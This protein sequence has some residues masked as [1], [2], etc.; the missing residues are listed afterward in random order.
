MVSPYDGPR[1]ACAA[2]GVLRGRPVKRMWPDALLHYAG[3]DVHGRRLVVQS[4]EPR[5][6]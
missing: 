5:N 6:S 3:L 4:V 2:V 1:C